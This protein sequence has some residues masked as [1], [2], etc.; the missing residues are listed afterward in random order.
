LVNK[1]IK[2]KKNWVNSVSRFQTARAVLF[3]GQ[4]R[5]SRVASKSSQCPFHESTTHVALWQL[6]W[7]IWLFFFPL[8]LLLDFHAGIKKIKS[9]PKVCCTL[10]FISILYITIFK[11]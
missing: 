2:K 8:S 4:N 11:I 1:K 3:G 9:A 5:D 10:D 6:M 7:R